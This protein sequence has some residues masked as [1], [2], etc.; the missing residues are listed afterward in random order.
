RRPLVVLL[1]A[2]AVTAA[3]LVYLA[4]HFAMTADT[5]GL[6]SSKLKWRQREIA[7]EN[8]FP[9]L[10]NLTL[11]VIDGA[12]PELADDA[13]K[14]LA[15]GLQEKP[16]LFQTVRRPDSGS[17]FE[18]EGLLLLPLKDVEDTTSGLGQAAPLMGALAADP[19]LRGVLAAVTSGLQGVEF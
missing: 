17:F 12:T 3:G 11:I 9:Q 4:G 15:K 5:A 16:E 14:R 10:Q 13:T 18:R 2:A 1:L 19:S 6:I 8:A 7:F